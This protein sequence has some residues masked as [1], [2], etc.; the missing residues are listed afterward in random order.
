MTPRE[1]ADFKRLE[2]QTRTMAQMIMFMRDKPNQTSSQIA[3]QFKLTV[4]EAESLLNTMMKMGELKETYD[5]NNGYE[6]SVA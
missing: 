6:W 5:S 2:K 1:I 4:E 3:K